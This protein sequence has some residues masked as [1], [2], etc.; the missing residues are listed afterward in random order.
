MPDWSKL[1]YFKPTEKWGN[2]D[3]MD[4][5]LLVA[6][7]DFRHTLGIPIHIM[8]GYATSGHS[9]QSFH[10]KGLAVDCRLIDPKTNKARDLATHV[11]AAFKSPFTGVG[12]YTWGATGPFLHL[13]VRPHQ[14]IRTIWVS[15]QPQVYK[16][17]TESFLSKTFKSWQPQH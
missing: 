17:L 12:I 2:P 9:S 3:K 5:R 13:D 10:Y 4:M 1:K 15:E 11:L 14:G 8:E 7:D 6:L 16:P